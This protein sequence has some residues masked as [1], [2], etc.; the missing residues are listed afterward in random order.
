MTRA[1]YPVRP[2]GRKHRDRPLGRSQISNQEG[3]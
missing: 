2:P 3:S 1:A